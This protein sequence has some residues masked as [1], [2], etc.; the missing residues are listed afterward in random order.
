MLRIGDLAHRTQV[1]VRMLRHYHQIGLVVPDQVDP[2]TGQRWYG[3]SQVGRVH[4]LVA[5]RGLG[6]SLEECRDLMADDLDVAQL[7]GMLRLRR[8]ELE[9]QIRDATDQLTDV[10]RRL[11]SIER[12]MTM[13]PTSLQRRALP[14]LRLA[15]VSTAVNDTTEIPDATARLYESLSARLA[16][17]GR[18]MRGRGVRIY[19]GADPDTIVVAAGEP[20]D[21][22]EELD[23]DGIDIVEVAA[24]P[25]AA[26]V[27]HRG[28][29]T[30]IADTWGAIDVA[31]EAEG[32]ASHGPYR[33]V[34]I[35]GDGDDDDWV[36]EL[37]FPV[38]PAGA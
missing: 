21:P 26:V 17:I 15:Q 3:E 34:H 5:L 13:T 30:D 24:Q 18:P 16:A 32:L 4:T 7:D 31:L 36:V 2:A 23:T 14:A 1:S 10:R 33:Q 9:R 20:L 29:R 19:D 25:D 8:V 35:S 28:P 22:D 11:Q 12:A 27:V 37:Q 38:R 6:L